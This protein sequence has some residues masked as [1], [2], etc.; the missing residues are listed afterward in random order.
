MN[1]VLLQL[2]PT[3]LA[4]QEFRPQSPNPGDEA[5]AFAALM[6]ILVIV[7]LITLVV[8]LA[9]KALVCYLLS[10]CISRVPEQFQLIEPW[11]VWLLMIPCFDLYWNFVVFAK[12]P[13]S[14]QAYFAS[15]GEPRN[16]DC[17]QQLGFWLAICGV[18]GI[19]P[20]VSSIAGP[21][22]LILLIILLV[23]FFD[24]RKQIPVKMG[25]I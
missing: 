1:T 15:I 4:W 5:A 6:T 22:A 12:I 23:K 19:I 3:F 2:A 10:L 24:L 8:V 13:Q 14:F 17:G 20:G 7:G 18:A 9:I 16:G 11:Q 21:A 25:A